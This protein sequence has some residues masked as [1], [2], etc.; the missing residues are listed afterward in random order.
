M[1]RR[2]LP[3]AAF[4]ARRTGDRHRTTHSGSQSAAAL[5]KAEEGA[6]KEEAQPRRPRRAIVRWSSI[7]SAALVLGAILALGL[8]F[9][10][11]A[12]AAFGL[13]PG[14]EGFQAVALQAGGGEA[15][16]AGAH[17]YALRTEI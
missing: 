17:T 13:R 7:R 15:S 4:A 5:P 14:T 1:R 10:P 12:E 2:Q 11:R 8:G 3:G 9:G 16:Q 6:R